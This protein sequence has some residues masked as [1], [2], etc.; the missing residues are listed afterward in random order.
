[1]ARTT[2][3]FQTT[4]ETKERLENLAAATRRSKGYLAND[5][6]ERYLAEEEAFLADVEAGLNDLDSGQSLTSR[7]LKQ[8]LHRHVD[9][10]TR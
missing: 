5:A 6:V 7:E 4:P 3:T 1:M 8:S 9:R 2:F 10:E